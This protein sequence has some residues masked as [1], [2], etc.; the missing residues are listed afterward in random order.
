MGIAWSPDQRWI[1]YSG[2]P[3]NQTMRLMAFEVA[4]DRLVP[5]GDMKQGLPGSVFWL[6]DSQ[7]LLVTD[8]SGTG[9]ARKASF[10]L[11]DLAGQSTPLRDFAVGEPPSYAFPI[12][13][14]TAIVARIATHDLRLAPLSG[15]GPER[16]LLPSFEAPVAPALSADRQWLALRRSSAA[17]GSAGLNVIEFSKA[18]GS[19]RT[20]IE[21]PFM[22]AVSGVSLAILPGA[23]ELLVV[24]QWRPDTDP[25]VYLVTVATK[26]VKKLFTYPSRPGRSGPPDIA[27]SADGQ[28][29]AYMVW[30]TMTPTVS[31]I[32]VSVF[33]QPGR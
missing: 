11:V 18:D 20:T 14:S 4:T 17:D 5:L 32:D 15:D 3:P 26:A 27:L 23:K 19:A 9:S 6:P 33:R 1:S 30:E 29:I 25:G 7:R 28:S 31:A 12:D 24:E 8:Q 13:A 22:A 10:R 2:T 16:V 21:L